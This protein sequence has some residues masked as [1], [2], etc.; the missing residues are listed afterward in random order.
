MTQ[1]RKTGCARLLS[2][3]FLY[4]LIRH[5]NIL[6]LQLGHNASALL[7]QNGRVTGAISQERFNNIKNS[8][9]FPCD[10]IDWLL[11]RAGITY[12]QLDQVGV[13]GTMLYPEL[14]SKTHHVRPM[15]ENN[16]FLY[17]LYKKMDYAFGQSFLMRLMGRCRRY[18]LK[19]VTKRG[20][21]QFV[22]DF[23]VRGVAPERIKCVDHH[24]CHA[25]APVG[26]FPKATSDWLVFTA[27]GDGDGT[28]S[29]VST[30]DGK[31]LKQLAVTSTE[32]SLGYF[33]GLTTVFM[34]MKMLEHEYK[35]MGLAAYAK[36]EY[37]KDVYDKIFKDIVRFDEEN[38]LVFKSSFPLTRAMEHL[39]KHASCC[40]RFDNLA[41]AL[42]HFLEVVVLQWVQNAIKETGITQVMT[43]GGLFMN[44]KLNKMIREL[45]E[46]TAV[47][48]MPSCGD[49]TNPFGAAYA[50]CRDAGVELEP[51]QT[52]YQ[53]QSYS[54]DEIEIFLNA[55]PAR[56][57]FSF[58]KKENIKE[59]IADLLSKRKVVA[60]F[61]GRA[62]F[63]AR[64]L[65]NRA[66]LAHPADMESFFTV[67]D[68]IKVRDF[69]MPF[70]PT[71][72]DVDAP[73]YIENPK[74]ADAPYMIDAFDTT[75]EGRTALRAA[76]HQADKS[77]R[78]QI[79]KREANSE[80]YDLIKAFKEKS[81]IGA[82]MNTS[83]N[84]HG[85]PLASNLDQAIF[86]MQNSDLEYLALESWLVT[87]KAA[88]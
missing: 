37:F 8:N 52:L 81:K 76:L 4:G 42:Q 72:L 12:A 44:V 17:N 46:I 34:G 6:T 14:L 55:H 59:T 58:E 25:Y 48:F 69:W 23:K 10:A 83:F 87:K 5:M 11:Q 39:K 33:Y 85:Y 19:S 71:I 26:F 67:N 3:N 79:L 45:P 24:L 29:T 20:Y 66:I 57:K 54:D 64:S 68:Q 36:E 30:W 62:E 32:N 73:R 40:V 28:S 27:D 88:A 75:E 82:I 56:D 13:C 2:S 43:S 53:G 15:Y 84:L 61:A 60:R 22:A 70:A 16:K 38:P 51:V 41:G 80:Y 31:E 47:R 18:F 65:G 7:V 78:P 86:T 49:E 21:N 9:Q 63:G 50:L 35:V 77:V 74:Q 1:E